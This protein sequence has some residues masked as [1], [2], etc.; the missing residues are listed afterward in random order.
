MTTFRLSYGQQT[1]PGEPERRGQ[2]LLEIVQAW[3]SG[4]ALQAEVVVRD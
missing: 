1:S 4:S 2:S 3:V